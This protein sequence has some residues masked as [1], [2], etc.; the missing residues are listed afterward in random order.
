MEIS[1]AGLTADVNRLAIDLTGFPVDEVVI[2]PPRTVLKT[3]SGKLRRAACREA[4]E[5]GTLGAARSPWAAWLRYSIRALGARSA[6]AAR[7]ARA[8]AWGLRA[9]LVGSLLVPGFSLTL[10]MTPGL[11]RR[12]RAG[13]ALVRL[14]LRLSGLT[15]RVR[16][17]GGTAGA[18]AYVAN[19]ASYLD[20]L[21][22]MQALPADVAF[23]AKREF[24]GHPLLGPLLRR[25]GCVFVERFERQEAAA[26]ARAMEERLRHGESLVVFPEGTFHRAP[27]LLPF[28]LGAFSAAAA[29][30]VPVVPVAVCGS[31][32][33]LPEGARLP[34]PAPLTIVVGEPLMPGDG[35]WRSAVALRAA[36]RRHI[37]G[38]IGEADLER[39]PGRSLP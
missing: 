26:G 18:A 23:V 28:H 36:A 22:L 38:A 6:H 20:G 14:A 8:L 19:H 37:L 33:V 25:I 1:Q 35:G 27:G 30:G 4:L 7:R 10:A 16:R 9:L 3:S 29:A 21:L 39:L 13:G 31:R 2:A 15:P 11:A 5:H 17:D 32:S 34:R 24:I 12:R